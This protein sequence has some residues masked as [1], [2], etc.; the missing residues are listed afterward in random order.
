M[1]DLEYLGT[2]DLNTGEVTHTESA[3]HVRAA[4]AVVVERV[5]GGV[6]QLRLL[7]GAE[8]DA[9]AG[10]R[11]LSTPAPAPPRV[12]SARHGLQCVHR[13]SVHDNTGERW[14]QFTGVAQASDELV[15]M[16]KQCTH[17]VGF[18]DPQR[19]ANAVLIWGE[20]DI[21][22]H[23]WDN[24]ARREIA[25]GDVLVFAK[26]DPEKPSAYN[27]DDSNQRDDPAFWER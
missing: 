13:N 19:W 27:Y 17:F 12:L 6:W 20:P 21:V 23:V 18:R 3:T 9:A 14:S 16:T 5:E 8:D 11:P 10:L 25:D 24:R 15:D 1:A 2:W 22:H 26:Y 7:T 4:P